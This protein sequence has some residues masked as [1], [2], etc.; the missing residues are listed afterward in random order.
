MEVR[1]LISSTVF[2]ILLNHKVLL[3]NRSN[4]ATTHYFPSYKHTPRVSRYDQDIRVTLSRCSAQ[5]LQT[6]L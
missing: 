4:L 3:P 2:A 5:I 6:E 1:N